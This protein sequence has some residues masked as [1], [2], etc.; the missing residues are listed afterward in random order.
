MDEEVHPAGRMV[1]RRGEGIIRKF[2]TFEQQEMEA[3][4]KGTCCNLE[5]S[6]GL[7]GLEEQR[8]SAGRLYGEACL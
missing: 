6:K 3:G 4:R 2:N 5:G 8:V 1:R 7:I